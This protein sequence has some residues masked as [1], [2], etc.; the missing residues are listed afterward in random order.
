MSHDPKAPRLAAIATLVSGALLVFSAVNL[1]FNFFGVKGISSLESWAVIGAA[2]ASIIARFANEERPVPELGNSPVQLEEDQFLLTRTRETSMFTEQINPTTATIINSILGDAQ[3]TNSYQ[4][5]SA[6]DTLSSGVFGASV[7]STMQESRG[8]KANNAN[9]REATPADEATGLTLH[10]VHV[11]PVPLPGRETEPVVD[12][13]QIPGLESNRIFVRDGMASVPLPAAA[14]T[15]AAST[16][17][18]STTAAPEVAQVVS[19][20]T[21]D[22][23]FSSLLVGSAS[24][25]KFGVEVG[26][27]EHGETQIT[28]NTYLTETHAV[29]ELPEL[30]ELHA[31]PELPSVP[32]LPAVPELPELPELPA[33][34]ELEEHVAPT[35]ETPADSPEIASDIGFDVPNMDLPDLDDLFADMDLPSPQVVMVPATPELPNLDDLF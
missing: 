5:A 30:P 20:L 6:I 24:D 34:P 13:K 11:Q 1:Y 22:D 10:R 25:A 33:L 17:A 12:P 14:S 28:P 3:E 16:T 7:L 9:R 21:I 15:T 32:E 23:D 31:V 29:P 4:V 8:T 27:I 19:P 18:A 35:Q 2:I 26:E